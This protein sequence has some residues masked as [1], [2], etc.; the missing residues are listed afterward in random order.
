MLLKQKEQEV[1]GVN[2]K[3]KGNKCD[4]D[5]VIPQHKQHILNYIN[6]DCAL[7]RSVYM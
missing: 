2:A 7:T 4:W 5:Y 6:G 3:K 1:W